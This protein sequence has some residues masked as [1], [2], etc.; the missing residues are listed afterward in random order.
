M[1]YV[2]GI[3]VVLLVVGLVAAAW[4]GRARV[5]SCCTD[6]AHDRRMRAAFEGKRDSCGV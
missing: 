1:V 3:L 2:L 6:P 5:R 4:T